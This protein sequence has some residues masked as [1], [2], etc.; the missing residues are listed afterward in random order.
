M[1]SRVV[2][3][4]LDGTLAESA[5]GVVN[6]FRYAIERMG[7]SFP[8]GFDER[9]LVGPPLLWSF[10][11]FWGLGDAEAERAVML[12]R[13]Y[14]GTRGVFEAGLY[15]GVEQLL[16]ELK[17]SG[18]CLCIATSKYGPMAKKMLEYLNIA[19]YFSHLAMSGGREGHSAK[20]ELI[21]DCLAAT[22]A[23]AGRAVMVG[24]TEFDAR[25]ARET[26]VD[27]IGVLYGY[28]TR[29]EMEAQGASIFA[30][31]ADELKRL[32]FV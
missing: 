7:L 22:G 14:Y 26:G 3:F 19:H 20:H 24:D 10:S 18:V 28:G 11:R 25:G 23:K 29:E 12:Y 21:A 27:F 8:P 15:P 13:E 1:S 4:D 30:A 32:L 6:G 17:E 5:S 16:R 9:R 2:L 31:D